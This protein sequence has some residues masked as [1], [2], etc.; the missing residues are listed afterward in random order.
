MVMPRHDILNL[1]GVAGWNC[2]TSCVSDWKRGRYEAS[3]VRIGFIFPSIFSTWMFF[4]SGV[5]KTLVAFL[6][7]EDEG[8]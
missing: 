7:V 8:S 4:K 2:L 3:Y 5:S 6:S 1:Q